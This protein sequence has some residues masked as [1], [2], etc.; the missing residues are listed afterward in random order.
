M[1]FPHIP[2][3]DPTILPLAKSRHIQTLHSPSVSKLFRDFFDAFYHP[4]ITQ[5]LLNAQLSPF[6]LHSQPDQTI[7]ILLVQRDP[8]CYL[9]AEMKKSLHLPF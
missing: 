7:F 1:K 2:L 5:P 8:R 6:G 3:A 4:T 9:T